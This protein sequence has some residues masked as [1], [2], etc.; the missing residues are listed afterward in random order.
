[1]RYTLYNLSKPIQTEEKPPNKEEEAKAPE[2]AAN[3]A[4]D[5]PAAD[6]DEAGRVPLRNLQG[7]IDK[8]CENQYAAP[9]VNKVGDTLQAL[10]QIFF[11]PNLLHCLTFLW[12]VCS[13]KFFFDLDMLKLMPMN[14]N[15]QSY[16]KA[17]RP[18]IQEQ[19][20]DEDGPF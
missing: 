2:A 10:P 8:I 1:M 16:G 18:T 12:F 5:A 19:L 17:R 20:N 14:I 13:L 7:I 3:A 15:L 6:A 4:P 11:I 9:I